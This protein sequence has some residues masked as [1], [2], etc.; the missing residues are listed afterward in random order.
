LHHHH[1]LS[2][3]LLS[4]G[5]SP[6]TTSPVS[7]SPLGLGPSL[8]SEEVVAIAG[9]DSQDHGMLPPPALLIHPCSAPPTRNSRSPDSE[10]RLEKAPR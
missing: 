7:A 4:A 5:H 9:G 1:S 10:D 3:S 2:H 8:A 6:A